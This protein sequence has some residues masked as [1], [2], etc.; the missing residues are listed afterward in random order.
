MKPQNFEERLVWYSINGTYI[1]YIFGLLLPVNALLGWVLF[2]YLCKRL[3]SQLEDTPIE[4]QIRV[5]WEIW[6]WL[7]SM[8]IML[9]V[10][11]VG[12]EDFGSVKNDYI[13]GVIGWFISWALLA[14][15]PFVG[16]L[17][18]RPQLIYRAVCMLCLQSLVF[19]PLSYLA[20]F[21]HLPSLIYSSPIER[22]IQNGKLYYNVALY[23]YTEYNHELRLALFA[24]W[25]PALGLAATLYFF[26]AIQEPDKR[27]QWIGAFGAIAM[28]AGSSSRLA[29]IAV[30]LILIGV[31]LLTNFWKPKIQICLGFLSFAFSIFSAQILLTVKDLTETVL[32]SRSS[33]TKIRKALVEVA[34][35]R[36]KEAPIWGHGNQEASYKALE[37]M[38]IGSHTT[39]GGLMFM[40]GTVG[41][42]TFLVPVICTLIS[43][44]V[45]AQKN[46]IARLGLTLLL[47]MLFFSSGESLDALA[48]LFWPA[49]MILGIALKRD[50]SYVDKSKL[51]KEPNAILDNP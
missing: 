7:V 27:W 50:S 44:L 49:L 17:N 35:E 34:F 19:I 1:F 51:K 33:S 39:W 28:C 38:P 6:F 36:S 41:L 29:Y 48:Y 47:V 40:H 37:N 2:V 32:G 10:R 5:P 25:A 20:Y 26:L 12:L 18:I 8:L 43:L 24:P 31:W 42:F 3:W 30:P 9:F 46:K 45:K 14:L 22:V 13:R 4:R 15:F 23:H 11:V 16:C 21:I